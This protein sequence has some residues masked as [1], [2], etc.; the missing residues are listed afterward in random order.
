[1]DRLRGIF[2]PSNLLRN[3]NV[4][5]IKPTGLMS[6]VTDKVPQQLVVDDTQITTSI[7]PRTIQLQNSPPGINNAR[8][9]LSRIDLVGKQ[10]G[11]ERWLV[12][13]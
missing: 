2:E 3:T 8:W 12:T 13:V 1:M 5:T 9:E 7:Q 6:L 10:N 11:W 4:L